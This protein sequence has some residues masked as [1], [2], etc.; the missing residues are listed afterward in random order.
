MDG[1]LSYR[2]NTVS[3]RVCPTFTQCI[4]RRL[5]SHPPARFLNVVQVC[6]LSV[7]FIMM[8]DGDIVDDKEEKKM[9]MM[10]NIIHTRRSTS[11]ETR[12]GIIYVVYTMTF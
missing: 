1:A 3:V 8:A 4:N 12:L 11:V 9:M 6:S 7:P 10:M 5:A 2:L